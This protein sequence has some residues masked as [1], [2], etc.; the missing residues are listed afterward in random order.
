MG[1]RWGGETYPVP[2]TAIRMGSFAGGLRRVSVFVGI[3]VG[4]G[5]TGEQ[6]VGRRGGRTV[7]R[8][9]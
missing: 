3:V 8:A 5:S 1:R 4:G 2:I 7:G 9:A 6:G